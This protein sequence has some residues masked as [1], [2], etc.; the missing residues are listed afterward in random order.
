MKLIIL[1]FKNLIKFTALIFIAN[2][3]IV[4]TN[5]NLEILMD[6]LIKSICLSILLVPMNLINYFNPFVAK[7]ATYHDDICINK[8][9][10]QAF[11]SARI[12]LK[13]MSDIKLIDSDSENKT[14]ILESDFSKVKIKLS[15]INENEVK[16][17]F[18]SEPKIFQ[19]IQEYNNYV[20]DVK[21]I[22]TTLKLHLIEEKELQKKS[23]QQVN[24]IE[25]FKPS[26]IIYHRLIKI[27]LITTFTGLLLLFLYNFVISTITTVATFIFFAAISLY[28][29]HQFTIE[30]SEASKLLQCPNCHKK[31]IDKEFNILKYH[32]PTKCKHCQTRLLENHNL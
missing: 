21:N 10:D 13:S 11:K 4:N 18:N 26:L 3:A 19:K 30:I 23:K 9:I 31:I 16:F 29:Y 12:L 8:P 7:E 2:L 17:S 32:I 15:N 24:F 22:I 6:I 25:E 27:F 1:I 20:K 5:L 28:I 14:L